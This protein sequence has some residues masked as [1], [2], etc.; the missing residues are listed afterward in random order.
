MAVSGDIGEAD[1]LKVQP[2]DRALA[3][4]EAVLADPGRLSAADI[5]ERLDLPPATASRIVGQ[6]AGRGMLK[7]VL[8]SRRLL[9]GP[10]LMTIGLDAVGAAFRA[11]RPHLLL[12]GLAA[13]LGEHCQIG[14]VRGLEVLYVDS[15]R[16]ARTGSLHFEPGERAPVHC[17]STGKLYLAHLPAAALTET[18]R[19]LTLTRFTLSTITSRAVLRRDVHAAASRGWAATDGEFAA[20]V[21]GCAAPIVSRAGR[22][23]G[24]VGVSLPEVRQ[25]FAGIARYAPPLREIATAIAQTLEET[26]ETAEA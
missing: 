17:T 26:G 20:G 24:A 12:A 14:I 13:R 9:A 22:F 5:A 4:I 2:F 16:A 11:D 25:S 8:G 1:A 7:R 23:V 19:G 6:L 15:A 21:V 18:L 3:V 10:R